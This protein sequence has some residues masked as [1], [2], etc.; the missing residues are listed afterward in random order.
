VT[1]VCDFERCTKESLSAEMQNRRRKPGLRHT[2]LGLR[3]NLGELL[4]QS[5]A[6]AHEIHGRAR[7]TTSRLRNFARGAQA[8]FGCIPDIA[9]RAKREGRKAGIWSAGTAG[10]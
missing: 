8:R 1:G 3:N 2:P 9:A 4:A 6:I 10:S 5:G 7:P